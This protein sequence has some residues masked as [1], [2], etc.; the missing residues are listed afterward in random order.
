MAGDPAL[1]KPA[2]LAAAVGVEAKPAAIDVA[3]A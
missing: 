3:R 2:A 1:R